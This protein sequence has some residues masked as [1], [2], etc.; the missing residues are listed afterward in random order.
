MRIAKF[1]LL[2]VILF[3]ICGFATINGQAQLERISIAERADELGF[4]VR[5]HLTEMADSFRVARPEANLIQIAL[6][7]PELE[8]VGVTM[9]ALPEPFENIELYKL[10]MGAGIE[11]T[12]SED[13]Y[14][15]SIAYPDV[16]MR[17]VL[18]ALEYST[19]EEVAR[20]VN[21]E[22][23]FHWDDYVPEPD[24]PA[25]AEQPEIVEDDEEPVI[26]DLPRR[27]SLDVGLRGGLSTSNFYGVGY[28][29]DSRSGYSMATIF[30]VN[31]PY[32]LPYNIRPSLE[33][34]VYFTQKGYENPVSDKFVAVVAE[35]DYIEIPVLAKLN[36]DVTPIISPHVVFGPYVGFM[37][38]A[39]RVRADDSRRDL[40]D[41]TR[42]VDTGF[43]AG[44]GADFRLGGYVISAQVRGSL[45]FTTIFSDEEIDDGEKHRHFSVLLGFTF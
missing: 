13:I 21:P 7:S 30:T 16:N 24:E 27:W 17:D 22:E 15:T 37:V 43:L 14:F 34:G 44:A 39:E 31:M 35:F 28:G 4:V 18:L 6:Y 2:S 32:R 33:T 45:G 5:F 25:V 29:R 42:E 9:S 38:N 40:D 19:Q 11:I 41:F 26:V 36:Y 23:R 8:T 1:T 10:E 3:L 12:L 20:V